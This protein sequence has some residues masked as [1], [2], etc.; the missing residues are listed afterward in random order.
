MKE[1]AKKHGWGMIIGLHIILTGM[2]LLSV[3]LLSGGINAAVV[4]RLYLPAILCTLGGLGLLWPSLFLLRRLYRILAGKNPDPPG[5]KPADTGWRT[6]RLFDSPVGKVALIFVVLAAFAG[7]ITFLSIVN[8]HKIAYEIKHNGIPWPFVAFMGV[9]FATIINW[10]AG[11]LTA[12]FRYGKGEL[13]LVE[14]P[15]RIGG[16]F[17]ARFIVHGKERLK[18]GLR[19]EITCHRSD[20][21]HRRTNPESHT[22]D[23]L[24]RDE[25]EIDPAQVLRIGADKGLPITFRIPAGLPPSGVDERTRHTEWTVQITSLPGAKSFVQFQWNVPVFETGR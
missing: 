7:T 14:G 24:F 20:F 19:A 10:L 1:V 13:R 22:A 8:A 16:T 2:L 12:W 23:L 15:G 4:D 6:G 21:R 5:T 3:M 25:I 9:M 18:E 17:A 11:L